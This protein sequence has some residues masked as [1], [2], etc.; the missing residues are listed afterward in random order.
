MSASAAEPNVLEWL[1]DFADLTYLLGHELNN[2]LNNLLLQLSI[3]E[4]QAGGEKTSPEVEAIRRQGRD[5][6]VKVHHFQQLS[7]RHR[8]PPIAVDLN[9]AVRDVVEQ[10]E[11]GQAP[12]LELKLAPKLA[13][14]LG[15]PSDLRHLILLVVEAA[16]A[17]LP[18]AGGSI[19][20]RSEAGAASARLWIED[21]GAPV[22]EQQLSHLFEPF[23]AVR[24]GSDGLKLAICRALV[25]RLQ[26]NVHAVNRPEG[27]LSVC[28]ELRFASA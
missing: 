4:L 13:P 23:A 10:V 22:P 28:V 18:P 12:G 20:L 2:F 11:L 14:V 1:N 3:L 24:P 5:L 7:H 8:P 21:S 9:Q 17:A 15:T 19:T 25:R 16:A 6:A 26:G 27:G